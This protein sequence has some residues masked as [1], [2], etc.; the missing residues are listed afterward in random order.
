MKHFFID[1][2]AGQFKN[3]IL[4]NFYYTLIIT[5]LA[6]NKMIFIHNLI[7]YFIFC[8]FFTKIYFSKNIFFFLHKLYHLFFLA[9]SIFIIFCASNK[10][11]KIKK[12]PIIITDYISRTSILKKIIL[13]K[14]ICLIGRFLYLSLIWFL[15]TYSLILI[16]LINFLCGNSIISWTNL[17]NIL[18]RYLNSSEVITT[19]FNSFPT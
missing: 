14:K 1:F 6:K 9:N 8:N 11:I 4:K 15:E 18:W 3:F 16:L 19:K 10:K 5:Q 2:C 7:F 17:S 12:P 13:N